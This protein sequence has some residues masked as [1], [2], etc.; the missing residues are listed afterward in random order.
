M[1]GC[2]VAEGNESSKIRTNNGRVM[3]EKLSRNTEL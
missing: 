3:K 1:A 2:V